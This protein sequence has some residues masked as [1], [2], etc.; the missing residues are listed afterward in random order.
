MKTSGIHGLIGSTEQECGRKRVRYRVFFSTSLAL[1]VAGCNGINSGGSSGG[2]SNPAQV[3]LAAGVGSLTASSGAGETLATYT[4]D[5]TLNTFVVTAHGPSGVIISTVAGSTTST[6]TTIL[7]SGNISMLS[8]GIVPLEAT[9]FPG[10]VL[11][12]ASQP[13]QTGS[14]AVEIPGQ[15]ALVEVEAANAGGTATTFAPLVA[16][17]SCPSLQSPLSF[18]FVTIPRG[19]SNSGWNPETETAYGSVSV[20]TSGSAVQLSNISQYTLPATNGGTPG[21]PANAASSM[22][23]TVCSQTLFGETMS[24]PETVTVENP[25]GDSQSS[26]PAA[27]IGISSSG[28]LLEDSGS[29]QGPS[30]Y[31][32][33]LGAGYGAIGLQK[34]SSALN[35]STVVGV[36]FQ[37]ILYGAHDGSIAGVSGPGFRLIGS[38]GYSNLAAACPTL[39]APSTSTILYGGEFASNDPSANAYGNC[40]LALDLG[41]QD[42]NNN[43]LYPGVTVYVSANFPYNGIGTAYSFPAVAIAGQINGKYAI[44]LVGMDTAGSPSQP[45]GIYLLQSN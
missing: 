23:A 30:S 32:N 21:T 42:P 38:F 44:F 26:S 8:N 36:Q 7:E 1:L 4:L 25:G 12:S 13:S 41:T 14:W 11:S 17:Q 33:V 37:G 5:N 22:A 18:Q 39:P 31:E 2:T 15:A 29:E 3:Y 19:S 24:I 20:S 40:D 6:G 16:T 34:P 35:T 43:G 45:W 10:A 9:Y 28:F 27:T